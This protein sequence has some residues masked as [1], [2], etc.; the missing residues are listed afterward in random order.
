MRVFEVVNNWM[1]ESYVRVYV[2]AEN[3]SDAL[4]LARAKFQEA[5]SGGRYGE[6]YHDHLEIAASMECRVGAVSEVSNSG[7]DLPD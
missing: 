6:G 5:E 3:E 4:D 2:I 1:G 7:M